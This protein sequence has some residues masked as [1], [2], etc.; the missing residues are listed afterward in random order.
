MGLVVKTVSLQKVKGKAKYKND[1]L[2]TL[3]NSDVKDKTQQKIT[4]TK[5]LSKKVYLVCKNR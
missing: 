3:A 5:N 2:L 1:P 4:N